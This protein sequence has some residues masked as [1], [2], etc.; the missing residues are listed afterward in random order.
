VSTTVDNH[1]TCANC[2][3]ELAPAAR[4]CPSCRTFVHGAELKSLAA[5]AAERATANDLPGERDAWSRAL[6][7]LPTDT[8][9][10][11]TIAARI[12]ALN[13]G[14]ARATAAQSAPKAV[15]GPWW[16]RGLA[17]GAAVVV[18]ALSKLKFLLLGLTKVS[19]FVSMFAFFGVYWNAFG[20]PLA[21]GLVVSIY[22]HEM[23]HVAMLKRLGI[24][25]GAPVFIPGLGALVRLRQHVTDPVVDARIGLAGPIWGL[26][27]GIA[28]YVVGAIAASPIWFAIAQLTGYVNLF[29]LIPVW[30]LDGARGFHAL[31]RPA[32]LLVAG[33]AIAMFLVTSQRLLIL[34]AAVAAFQAFR[35]TDN[36]TDSRTLL[37]FLVL[38]LSLSMLAE[39]RV[40]T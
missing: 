23:G 15:S 7:L 9:Q 2:A 36:R 19:T 34:V 38:I 29:N 18:L 30:Q 1:R 3:T 22:I 32:R 20:W 14:I 8:Q 5:T 28:A 17:S 6:D 31:G 35:K 4:V 26:G 24:E 39:I 10:Y 37:E 40:A 13:A 16:K 27:A 25:A 12:A 33:A 21:L 11:A